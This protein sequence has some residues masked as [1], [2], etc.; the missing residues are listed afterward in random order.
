MRKRIFPLAAMLLL[1]VTLLFSGCSYQIQVEVPDGNG[2]STVYTATSDD[3]E[4]QV[5]YL[6]VGQGDAELIFLPDGTTVLI[7]S[8][9]QSCINYITDSLED[10]GVEEI[11]ILIASHP[12]ADHIGCMATVVRN[13]D[14]GT[15]YMP[16]TSDSMTP[17]T[18]CYEKLLESIANKNLTVKT[19]KSGV[20]AYENG[21]V[22]LEFLAPNS[23]DYSNLN[24]YSIVAKLTYGDTSFL[25]MGDA[26]QASL[27]EMLDNNVDLR[28]DVLKLGHHGSSNAISQAFMEAVQ[29]TYGII[30]CGADNSY[31]HPHKEALSLL[32]QFDVTTY[33]TDE[34]NTIRATSDGKTIT[35]QTGLPSVLPA[36]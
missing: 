8:G 7:D 20:T 13:F 19:G 34:D 15:I 27:N 18:V 4:L 16:K 9:D 2:G 35:F 24:N 23:S 36:A 14:I 21:S 31:G 6:D 10:Y 22:K 26:E 1:A 12:H 32:K 28:C 25:F 3:G 33:R 17:T 30:S 5:N 11:D 29:P